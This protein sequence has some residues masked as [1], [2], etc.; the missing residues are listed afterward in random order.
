MRNSL[1]VVNLSEA[2]FECIFGR[3]FDGMCCQN[4]R[5][6]LYP[7]D[8]T[9]IEDNLGKFLPHVRP[10]ARA[11]IADSGYCSKRRKFDMPMLRVVD[12][13]CVFFNQGCVFHKVGAA[14]G[15]PYRY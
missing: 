6:S 2:K 8:L 3:G 4:G 11:V 7:E 5:P 12:G 15:D 9:A 14:E 10:E 13:W 1:P